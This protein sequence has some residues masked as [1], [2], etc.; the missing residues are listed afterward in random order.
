VHIVRKKIDVQ[1][2]EIGMYVSELDRPWLGTPFL[3]Q[4]F[5]IRSHAE[6]DELKRYCQWVYVDGDTTRSR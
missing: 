5:E 2:L 1:Y 3:F 6:I 4:G